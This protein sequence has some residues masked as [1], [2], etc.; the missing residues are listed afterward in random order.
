[1]F[2]L[3]LQHGL[4]LFFQYIQSLKLKYLSSIHS[5]TNIVYIFVKNS[6]IYYILF[7]VS[8]CLL[9]FYNFVIVLLTIVLMI[10]F[11]YLY[12]FVL[13]FYYFHQCIF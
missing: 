6:Y 4:L 10:L 1:M 7:H 5:L 3:S 8:L 13:V 2:I 12:L 11:C 9:H